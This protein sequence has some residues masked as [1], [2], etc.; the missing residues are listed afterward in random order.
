[1]GRVSV[2]LNWTLGQWR[3]EFGIEII[4]KDGDDT[5]VTETSISALSKF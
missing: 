5:E 1:M 2:R 4:K 3:V